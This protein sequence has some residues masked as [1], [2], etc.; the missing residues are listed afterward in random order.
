MGSWG[1]GVNTTM[2]ISQEQFEKYEY[3]LASTESRENIN[4]ICEQIMLNVDPEYIL[5]GIGDVWTLKEVKLPKDGGVLSYYE[6]HPF[7]KKGFPVERVVD[8]VAIVKKVA[9]TALYTLSKSKVLLVIMILFFHKD[10]KQ[11]YE[12]LI[13]KLSA[14]IGY[15]LLKPFRY[16]KSVQELYLAFGSEEKQLRNLVCM[17][18]EFD[19]AYRYRLQDILGELD[20]E[21]LVT[22]PYKE[23]SRLLS[24][25]EFR[26]TDDRLQDMFARV[27]KAL[28]L[29]YISKKLRDKVVNFFLKLDIQ[30]IKMEEDD[31]YFAKRKVGNYPY[32]WGESP[33]S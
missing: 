33:I 7:P 26:D 16:C 22:S 32:K 8:R 6:E 3:A 13:S 10:L 28:F 1:G 23:L 4:Y 12:E 24:I 20:K 31:M 29:L 9:M 15:T 25:A 2:E 11:A 30:N 19:D 17:I 5:G 18:F 27:R 21:N 14:L